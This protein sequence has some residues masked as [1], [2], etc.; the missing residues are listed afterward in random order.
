MKKLPKPFFKSKYGTILLILLGTGGFTFSFGGFLTICNGLKNFWT[1]TGLVFWGFS[2]TAVV[3]AVILLLELIPEDIAYGFGCA[4]Y[5]GTLGVWLVLQKFGI[6]GPDSSMI[7]CS[8]LITCLICYI[9][10]NKKYK[11]KYSNE[12]HGEE[13][14]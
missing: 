2:A 10:Y 7:A 14:D 13:K 5:Y 8:G 12:T 4:I 6:N 11:D 1:A 9:V 3:Y